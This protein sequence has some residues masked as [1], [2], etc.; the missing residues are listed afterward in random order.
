[1]E[2]LT[3]EEDAAG[4]RLDQW[5]AAAAGD[6]VSRSRVKALILE[7]HVTIN[8]AAVTEPRQKVHA[9]D[10]VTF[11][12]P[13][14]V[15]P[16][17]RGQAITLDVLYEDDQVIVIDK[18]AGLVVHPGQGNPDGTLVNALIH[19]C[20]DSLSGIGGVKRPGIV[21]RLDKDTSGVMVAA[22][23]DL[24]HKVLT[25]QFADHGR[26]GAL[27]RI[28]V[29]VVW[30]TVVPGNGI[31]STFLGR[32]GTDRLRQA[33]VNESQPDARHAITHYR[34]LERFGARK[35]GS[36]VASLVACTLETGRTH[37]IRV[38]MAHLGHPLIGDDTYGAGYRT[39]LR[40]LP[41][42]IA[43]PIQTLN[44]QALHAGN[45]AFEHP[46]TGD[47][48]DFESPMPD[49]MV[50]VVEALRTLA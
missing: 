15:D 14:P 27:E 9:G 49:D 41:P 42:E 45:L 40:A 36:A 19:H 7:G 50:A 6:L 16:V 35:D 2:E 33:V 12:P 23:T 32:S 5:L 29:A 25:A 4:R 24:A 13:P 44:R 21:H 8:G 26:T 1:M 48:M 28:Y 43:E 37:Q 39:K 18:P 47:V 30:G 17:P 46:T 22:K 38:H 31:V 10:R 3:V 20:G 34:T 11:S